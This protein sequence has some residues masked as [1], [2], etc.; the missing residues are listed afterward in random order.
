MLVLG[1]VFSGVFNRVFKGGFTQKN[2]VGFFGYVPGCPNPKGKAQ[3]G[4]FLGLDIYIRS[5]EK[6]FYCLEGRVPSVILQMDYWKHFCRER[7]V[8]Q[9]EMLTAV[10]ICCMLDRHNNK[11][12]LY[13]ANQQKT[14]RQ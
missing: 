14:F 13:L 3:R 7:V 4:L 1:R 12:S 6:H 10:E 9:V 5:R 2:P 11:I 8:I